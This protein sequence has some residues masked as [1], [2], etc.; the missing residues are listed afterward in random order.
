LPMAFRSWWLAWEGHVRSS[1]SLLLKAYEDFW[2]FTYAP[3]V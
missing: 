1:A 3:L 2:L